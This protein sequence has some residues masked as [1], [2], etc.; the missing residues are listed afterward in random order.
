MRRAIA[1][2]NDSE[3]SDALR[4]YAEF[5]STLDMSGQRLYGAKFRESDLLSFDKISFAVA[6]LR[7]CSF[8]IEGRTDIA[9]A[10]RRSGQFY[11]YVFR[12]ANIEASSFETTL[13]LG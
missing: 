12:A 5:S 2:S 7:S 4:R 13:V 9:A 10:A 1:S 3:R 6:T 8:N 11:R